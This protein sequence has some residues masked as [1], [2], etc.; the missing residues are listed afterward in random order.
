M[1]KDS[2]HLISR[3]QAF[4]VRNDL[5]QSGQKLVIAV[6]GG[7]DSMVMCH[8][9]R[10]LA[11]AWSWTLAAVHFNHH[12]RGTESTGD[13]EFVRQ[14]CMLWGIPLYLGGQEVALWSRQE[15]HSLESGARILRY[16]F[17]L[18][19]LNKL[20][21]DRLVTGHNADDQVETVLGHMLR[22]SGVTGLCGIPEQRGAV[23][24]PLLFADRKTIAQYA[25]EH[26]IPF[27]EDSSNRDQRFRRN[28]L[29]HQLIPELEIHYNNRVR[30][31]IRRLAENMVEVEAF[32]VDQA[33]KALS[34]CQRQQSADKII[35]DLERFLPY[36]KV[37]KKYILRLCVR[38]LGYDDRILNH[39]MFSTI[40]SGLER[41][42]SSWQLHLQ[43]DLYLW[44][45]SDAMEV[46]KRFVPVQEI[47]LPQPEKEYVL[48]EDWRLII[49]SDTVAL[50][51][52]CHNQDPFCVWVDGSVLHWPL[53]VKS[54]CPGDRFYPLHM[55]GSKS[56]ADFFIDNKVPQSERQRI[57]LLWS[58]D[59]LV[60]VGGLRLDDR[61]KVTPLTT[62]VYQLR[63]V[64]KRE[65]EIGI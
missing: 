24:R 25:R 30:Q 60:W 19:V 63:L 46:G 4:L 40:L 64:K 22:G 50:T 12:L 43:R 51:S 45:R 26:E 57:P 31:G 49:S 18:E 48:W 16:R 9:L 15:G 47:L 6:S 11:P 5:L 1:N 55:Q 37:L 3:L 29:R 8:A 39:V 32:L 44:I 20:G 23:V 28:R 10:T 21:F 34:E 54:I 53:R 59:R 7:M 14:Q 58:G 2:S 65:P 56:V 36:F 52:I 61:F 41:R 35:L 38:R 33:E 13:E 62:A 17:L 27:R 42:P